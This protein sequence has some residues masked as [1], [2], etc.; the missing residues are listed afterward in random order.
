MTESSPRYGRDLHK[1]MRVAVL[2]SGGASSGKAMMQDPE[3][4]KKYQV[5]VAGTDRP[6]GAKEK[7]VKMFREADIPVADFLVTRDGKKVSSSRGVFCKKYG[8][9]SDYWEAWTRALEEYG[10]DVVALSGLMILVDEPFSS[11]Y[12][13]RIANV[14]PA[15]LHILSGPRV[16][17]LDMSGVDLGTAKRI[18]ERNSLRRKFKGEDAVYDAVVEV[19]PETRSTVHFLAKRPEDYD[20]GVIAVESKAFRIDRQWVHKKLGEEDEEAVRKYADE[21]QERMK[22][23]GDGPAFTTLMR[24]MA[25]SKLNYHGNAVWY[26]G[27]QLDYE[28]LQ[29][30]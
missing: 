13:Y 20:E 21:L 25:D 9:V 23:E 28:G 19:E 24:E 6:K 1:P 2:F 18:V 5:V 4:G 12:R 7:G 16:D 22:W 29:L 14:H 8:T 10:V 11:D 26:R 3:H 17:R 27:R 15:A 30:E